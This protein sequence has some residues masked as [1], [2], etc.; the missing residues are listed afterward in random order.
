MSTFLRSV[1]SLVVGPPKRFELESNPVPDALGTVGAF[2]VSFGV[3]ADED[4]FEGAFLTSAGFESGSSQCGMSTSMAPSIVGGV[5]L[6]EE[7]LSANNNL[8]GMRGKHDLFRP[9]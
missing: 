1:E 3:G 7:V 9:H 2:V 5:G 8:T 6:N 4:D